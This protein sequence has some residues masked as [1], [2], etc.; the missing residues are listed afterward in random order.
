M[1]KKQKIFFYNNQQHG[2]MLLELMLVIAISTILIPFIFRYQQNTIERARNIEIVKKMDIVQRALEKCIDANKIVLMQPVNDIIYNSDQQ[3]EC[4]VLKNSSSQ[5]LIRYG[6]DEN[7]AT[8]YQNDYVLRVLKT[9]DSQGKAVLQGVVLLNNNNITA[10][11]TREIVDIGGGKLGY[12]KNNVVYG[13][14]NAFT[15]NAEDLGLEKQSGIVEMTTTFRGQANSP[16]LWRINNGNESDATMLTDL[17]INGHDVINIDK[18]TGNSNSSARIYRYCGVNEKGQPPVCEATNATF[19]AVPLYDQ[20]NIGVGN[21]TTAVIYGTK[22]ATE[23]CELKG[24]GT[25]ASLVVEDPNHEPGTTNVSGEIDTE[26]Y[27]TT[28]LFV[29]NLV[30]VNS[31]GDYSGSTFVSDGDTLLDSLVVT[32]TTEITGSYFTIPKLNITAC[33][34]SASD[35]NFFYDVSLNG[36]NNDNFAASYKDVK[37]PGLGKK[38]KKVYQYEHNGANSC[39]DNYKTGKVITEDILK[40]LVVDLG[41]DN[42]WEKITVGEFM[43]ALKT[44][45]DNI[46]NQWIKELGN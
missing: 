34:E 26:K 40:Y 39:V 6:L 16:Y 10:L 43:D 45:E 12:T 33:V 24:I 32:D 7:F 18:I 4:V 23:K 27:D 37:I 3:T 36:C 13:G 15:A 41:N 9:S 29:D 14:Y 25:N 44:M 31:F 20:T 11:R 30:K 28:N 5:G 1:M 22:A 17:N 19:N 38:M 42:A 8:D 2:G 46:Y 21:G 35:S